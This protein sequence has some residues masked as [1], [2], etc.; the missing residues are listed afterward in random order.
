MPMVT[1]PTTGGFVPAY[2]AQPDAPTPWPG[3]V[4]LHELFGLNDDIRSIAERFAAEGYLALAPDLLASGNR[5]T[6]LVRLLR[7][8]RS[9]QGRTVDEILACRDWLAARHDCSGRIGVAGF[10]LGGGFALALA[11][12]G[13]DASAA[14][15]GHLP[16]D[17]ESVL[18][19]AC[20]L[21]ASY[22]KRDL[23]LR[24]AA[25][26]LDR[27]LTDADVRHDVLEYAS[28]GHAFMS[29]GEPPIWARPAGVL[30]GLGYVELAA[31]DAWRRM[32]AMFDEELRLAGPS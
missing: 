22:G 17:A 6:C 16:R 8:A 20:P 12:R 32:L 11:A 15:Y 31:E 27:I 14:Q 29:R 13:F 5:L 28:A 10:C 4:V 30:M 3:V 9:A 1:V 19:G 26:R 18:I 21:V 7:D 23:T 24:G 25:A 2:L